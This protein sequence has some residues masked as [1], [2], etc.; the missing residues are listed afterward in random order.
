LE[1]KGL[2]GKKPIIKHPESN[3]EGA[4]NIRVELVVLKR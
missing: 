4:L 1:A 2:G 3:E